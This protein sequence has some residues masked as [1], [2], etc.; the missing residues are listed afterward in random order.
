V[1]QIFKKGSGGRHRENGGRVAKEKLAG[2]GLER[3]R[4]KRKAG[5]WTK[6]KAEIGSQ[7]NGRKMENNEK[8]RD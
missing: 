2:K 5:K 3:K 8:L 7:K 4:K 6:V 1:G